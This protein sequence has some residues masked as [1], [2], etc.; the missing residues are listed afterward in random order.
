[1]DRSGLTRH[2][3]VNVTHRERLVGLAAVAVFACCS[4]DAGDTVVW[5][6]VTLANLPC[7][8]CVWLGVAQAN[9][10]AFQFQYETRVPRDAGV[11]VYEFGIYQGSVFPNTIAVQAFGTSGNGCSG[12]IQ[13]SWVIAQSSQVQQAFKPGK[14][15]QV[16]LDVTAVGTGCSPPDGG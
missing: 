1:M 16:S 7:V 2:A 15:V 6:S 5:A 11:D 14:D 10:P 9:Q 13:Q 4:R 12:A 3:P 8:D